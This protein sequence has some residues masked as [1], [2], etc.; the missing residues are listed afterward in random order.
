MTSQASAF[1]IT[2][3]REGKLRTET[4]AEPGPDE[5]KVRTLYSA[6]SRGTE[7]LVFRGEVPP[8]EYER[9][10]APFQAGSFPAPVKYG[11]ISVGEVERGPATLVGQTVFC[12]YPHQTRYVV[13]AEAVVPLPQAVPPARAVLAANL[14]TAVN[15]LWDLSPKVGDKIAVIGAGAVG[16][17]VAWLAGRIPGCRVELVDTNRNRATIAAQLGVQFAVPEDAKPDADR[18]VHCSGSAAGLVTALHIAAFEATVLEMSWFGT[19]TV[20]LPLGK[21]FHARRLTLRSSH[22]GMVA[23]AQRIRW[24]NRRRLSLALDLLVD[25][26]LDCLITAESPFAEIPK[27]LARLAEDPGDTI[28]HRICYP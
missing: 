2:G 26:I 9:M 3:S 8:S 14:E 23:P 4:L 28:C 5:V 11:Y 7:V 25:P 10:R 15:G 6:L 27:V 12:L 19:R 16:C 17:L 1:W 21:S 22:V 20:E 18:V 13:A 24:S